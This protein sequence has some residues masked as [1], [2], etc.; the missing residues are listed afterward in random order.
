MVACPTLDECPRPINQKSTWRAQTAHFQNTPLTVS[1]ATVLAGCL[2]SSEA[3]NGSQ[4]PAKKI[5]S[6]GIDLISLDEIEE[7]Q[8][9]AGP[10][11]L[12]CSAVQ[13][14]GFT[15]VILV[16]QLASTVLVPPQLAPVARYWLRV[17]V[18]PMYSDAIQM[19]LPS[20]TAAP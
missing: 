18:W 11:R 9:L 19:L 2:D 5:L 20:T 8:R 4:K 3:R 12:C 16:S 14:A 6:N 10:L 17:H 15:W 13:P 7:A 1:L